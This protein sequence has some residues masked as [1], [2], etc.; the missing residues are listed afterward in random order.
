MKKYQRRTLLIALA[1]LVLTLP[2]ML[3]AA[4][5]LSYLTISGPGIKN[6]LT[7][8][9]PEEMAK[10]D[11]SGFFDVPLSAKIPEN[12]GEGYNITAHLNMDGKMV[13]FVEMVYYPAAE[14]E[15]GYIHVTGRFNGDS[16]STVDEWGKIRTSS[17]SVLRGLMTHAGVTIQPAVAAVEVSGPVA[18]QQA[19][20]PVPARAITS[21]FIPAAILLIILVAA[22]ALRTR[23]F[24]QREVKVKG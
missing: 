20:T 11:Q 19:Q 6:E 17:E 14:G 8:G 18:E 24:G 15:Q 4:K 12:L 10:L 7:L 3:V 21:W 22:L 9:N 16:V 13:P 1:L 2:T 5:E 23:T